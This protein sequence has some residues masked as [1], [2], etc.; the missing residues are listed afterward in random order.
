MNTC[1]LTYLSNN[2][3]YYYQLLLLPLL[4]V[5]CELSEDNRRSFAHEGEICME[6]RLSWCFGVFFLF[7]CCYAFSAALSCQFEALSDRRL[8]VTPPDVALDQM[9]L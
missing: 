7:L 9:S 4:Q 8:T 1:T 6:R 2:N 3:Y 5:Y